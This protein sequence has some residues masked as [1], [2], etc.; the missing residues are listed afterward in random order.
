MTEI[1]K[2]CSKH[3][4]NNTCNTYDDEDRDCDIYGE[5]HPPIL[6]CPIWMNRHWPELPEGVRLELVKKGYKFRRTAK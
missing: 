4:C 1:Q 2:W 3:R 6:Q 5:N